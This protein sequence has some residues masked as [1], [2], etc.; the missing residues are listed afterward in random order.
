MSED[1]K[2]KILRKLDLIWLFYFWLIGFI[3][4]IVHA[5]YSVT[6][7]PSNLPW[8][9]IVILVDGFL[10]MYYIKKYVKREIEQD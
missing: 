1:R 5:P 10:C 3:D 4:L 9:S 6:E 8:F 2:E 7:G